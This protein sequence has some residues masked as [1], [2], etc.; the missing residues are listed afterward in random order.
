MYQRILVP[1]DGSVLSERAMV[2]SIDLATQLGFSRPTVRE[3]LIALA[4]QTGASIG[5]PSRLPTRSLG[6]LSALWRLALKSDEGRQRSRK[7]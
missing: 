5:Y 4:E 2:A 3:A 7:T 6:R 1:V